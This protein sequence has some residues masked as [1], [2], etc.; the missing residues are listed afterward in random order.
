MDGYTT[1]DT[2]MNQDQ[3][4]EYAKTTE[5]ANAFATAVG[6]NPGG[7]AVV[8]GTPF[9]QPGT[10]IATDFVKNMDSAIDTYIGVISGDLD[11]LEKNPNVKAAFQGT[12]IEESIKRLI[13]NLRNELDSYKTSMDNAKKEIVEEIHTVYQNADT[14]IAADV[15]EDSAL[16]G[17]DATNTP[18][19]GGPG[20]GQVNAQ[21]T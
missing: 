21:T 4:Q 15:D 9:S 11:N 18:G 3:Y 17:Q 2:D 7:G 20:G 12:E 16:I 8:G 5:K 13:T 14:Q 10:G 19:V 1:I 6:E